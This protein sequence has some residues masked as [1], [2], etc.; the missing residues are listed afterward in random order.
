[1]IESANKTKLESI[2]AL[3]GLAF[4]F[5][6][7]EH[8]KLVRL[9][10]AGVSIFIIMSGFLMVYNNYAM[11]LNLGF[12]EGFLLAKS[13]ISKLYGLHI[14]TLVLA[15]PFL[16]K[17]LIWTDI[18]KIVKT[19]MIIIS[20]IV[21]LQSWIPNQDFFYALN[22]VSWYL[23]LCTFLYFSFYFILKRIKSFSCKKEA[24]LNIITV[25]IVM[26]LLAILSYS[27]FNDSV[28]SKWFTYIFPLYRLGDFYIGCCLGFLFTIEKSNSEKNESL[29]YTVIEIVGIL[30]LLCGMYI[31][32]ATEGINNFLSSLRYTTVFLPSSVILVYAFAKNKGVLT[33]LFSNKYLIQ[34]GNLS[35][36]TFLIHQL[37]IRYVKIVF[38]TLKV[39]NVLAI[40]IVSIAMT[41][42]FANVYIKLE[43]KIKQKRN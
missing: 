23:S 33:R 22:G 38:G 5:I 40:G 1:M 27:L 42:I 29:T 20:Q 16:L 34:V 3:R 41:I 11:Q 35:A 15:M 31:Y 12:R 4:L 36:Y 13:K 18:V 28:I 8:I 32:S 25:S 2:Q 7:F 14:V 26:S 10:A 30:L 19:I 43:K 17:G 6:F 21:L 37:V 9:G 24:V 39:D